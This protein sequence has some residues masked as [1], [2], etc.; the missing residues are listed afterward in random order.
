MAD[1]EKTL[2]RIANSVEKL[3]QGR[4]VQKAAAVPVGKQEV[5]SKA[6]SPEEMSRQFEDPLR[7]NFQDLAAAGNGFQSLGSTGNLD[8]PYKI[9]REK[10]ERNS[11]VVTD[12]KVGGMIA[13]LLQKG[14]GKSGLPFEEWLN[15]AGGR[16][17]AAIETNIES[18]LSKGAFGANGSVIERALNATSG[19][20]VVTVRTD[21]E[22]IMREAYLRSFPLLQVISSIPA[23]GLVHTYN[24]KTATGEAVTL[25][26]LGDLTDANADSTFVRKDNANIAII[27][28][29]RAISLKL[30][31]ASQQ[32]GM[33]FNLSGAENTEVMSALT[34]IARKNQAL[35]L[36]GNYSTSSKDLDDEEGNYDANAYDGLRTKLKNYAITKADDDNFYDLIDRCV[37]QIMNAG[38]DVSSIMG[39]MS[40]GGKR[41]LSGELMQF[42]RIQNGDNSA[43]NANLA[44]VGLLTVAD[45]LA[46]MLPIPA[47]AQSQG[48][49]YYDYSSVVTEDAFICDPN[50]MQLAYLGSP[51][52]VVL[53]LPVGF[54]NKLSNVYVVFLMNGLVLYIDGFHRK[55]RIPK[56]SV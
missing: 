17:K 3:N 36:Q 47:S 20:G 24:V 5:E 53:E 23:N 8:N 50:G 28:S 55:I 7:K 15:G 41:L 42:L 30:Q 37:G 35:I 56:Q 44:Q 2:Q 19:T 21:I 26:E 9:L 38:G 10:D 29:R 49:G 31:Y 52:P 27:A 11:F 45:T 25:G 43:V 16:Q 40:V 33:N 1:L 18:A 12:A 4:Q 13:T 34:S 54:D 14:A 6:I 51:N 39:L 48:V 22:P 32:S 46:K